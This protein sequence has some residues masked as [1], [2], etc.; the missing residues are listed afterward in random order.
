MIDRVLIAAC[1]IVCLVIALTFV[2]VLFEVDPD[3]LFGHVESED[4]QDFLHGHT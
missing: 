4:G 3:G 2:A 1:G